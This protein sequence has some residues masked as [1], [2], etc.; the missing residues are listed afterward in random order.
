MSLLFIVSTP[1][2]KRVLLPLAAAC[3]RK[4]TPWSCFFTH[5]G[6]NNL[7]DSRVAEMAHCARRVVVCEHSWARHM[8]DRPCPV[9]LGSQTQNSIMVGEAGRIIS[10]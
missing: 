5:D 8:G 6:V 7:E 9:E 3:R 4:G 10:L 1:Q 2:A